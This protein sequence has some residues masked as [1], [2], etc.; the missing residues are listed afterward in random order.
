MSAI[1]LFLINSNKVIELKGK[2]VKLVI[3]PFP[4]CHKPLGDKIS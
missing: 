4:D 3:L 1:K 2:S